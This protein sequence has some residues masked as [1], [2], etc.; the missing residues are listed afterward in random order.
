MFHYQHGLAIHRLRSYPRSRIFRNIV[1]SGHSHLLPKILPDSDLPASCFTKIVDFTALIKLS[2][3]WKELGKQ[4]PCLPL[5]PQVC[6]GSDNSDP[7]YHLHQLRLRAVR[8]Y[9]AM[10][11]KPVINS[12]QRKALFIAQNC[13]LLEIRASLDQRPSRKNCSRKLQEHNGYGGSFCSANFCYDR[14]PKSWYES[15]MG[16]MSAIFGFHDSPWRP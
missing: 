15:C 10:E 14:C 13:Q 11:P 8:T 7:L 6:G 9:K 4:F 12:V 1:D 5:G 16:G 2:Q 3:V